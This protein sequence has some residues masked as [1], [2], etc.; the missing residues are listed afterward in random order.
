M[1]SVMISSYC[2]VMINFHKYIKSLVVSLPDYI[3][4]L[5]QNEAIEYLQKQDKLFYKFEC[6]RNTRHKLYKMFKGKKSPYL[7]YSLEY[8]ENNKTCKT[9]IIKKKGK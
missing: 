1:F 8:K 3:L 4:S 6:D 7:I 2:D 9:I 5:G